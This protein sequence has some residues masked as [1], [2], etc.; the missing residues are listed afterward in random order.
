MVIPGKP[1]NSEKHV[2]NRKSKA[3]QGDMTDWTWADPKTLKAKPEFQRLIP[4]QSKGELLAIEESIKTEGC[5]DPLLV[6]KGRNI[7]LDGHT[8]RELCMTHKKQVKVR[9]IELP[10]EKAAVEFI[11]ELQRQRRNLTREAMSYF[12]G[13]DYNA[14]KMERGGKRTGHRAKGQSDPLPT[15]AQ[16]LADKYG[17]SE[18]TIKRDAV[19]AQVVDKIVDDYGEPEIKRTLLGPDV[20]L[21][22]GTARVLLKKSGPARQAAVDEL[23][24]HGALTRAKK[25]AAPQPRPKDIAQTLVAGLKSKGDGHARSVLQ[26]MARLLGME[27][28]EKPA[29]N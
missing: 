2:A 7:V 22:Q 21:T 10:N 20:K 18:K 12:R 29:D 11:L 5:R 16:Q 24:E 9:A 25:Q 4:L 19:F 8:R 6:W 17:V 28:T 15:T 27:V 3:D 26:Q 1:E 23:L 13:A 14:S